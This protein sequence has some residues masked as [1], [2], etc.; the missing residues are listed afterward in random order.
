MTNNKMKILFQT[1]KYSSLYVMLFIIFLCCRVI[2]HLQEILSLLLG[3]ELCKSYFPVYCSSTLMLECSRTQR[4]GV[5]S[6]ESKDLLFLL[7]CSV[8]GAKWGGIYFVG[9]F[10]TFFCAGNIE[11]SCFYG[12]NLA[13]IELLNSLVV[14]YCSGHI[15]RSL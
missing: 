13:H 2:C 14:V 1:S 8:S 6:P 3:K 15:I 12:Y 9:A 4:G 11:V 10:L 5:V 7:G